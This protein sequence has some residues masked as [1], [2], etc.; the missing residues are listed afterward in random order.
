MSKFKTNI[1]VHRKLNRIFA[2]RKDKEISNGLISEKRTTKTYHYTKK[3]PVF[4]SF[5]K[6]SKY[7]VYYLDNY[8]F[9][10]F[11]SPS[12]WCYTLEQI[13]IK[14]KSKNERIH[15]NT[16]DLGFNFDYYLYTI[17]NITFK[18]FLFKL[19]I[20]LDEDNNTII[21]DY[22]NYHK[23]G[24]YTE[25]SNEF[26]LNINNDRNKLHNLDK[27]NKILND[28]YRNELIEDQRRIE[29]EMYDKIKEIKNKYTPL[30]DLASKKIYNRKEEIKEEIGYNEL[31]SKIR[32]LEFEYRLFKEYFS[33][34]GFGRRYNIDYRS[35]SNNFSNL[36]II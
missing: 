15:I 34:E 25:K 30:I 32:M 10:F 4:R 3:N 26:L 13:E 18:D 7:I 31:Y 22:Y 12:Y 6:D 11:Y 17:D 2:E 1:T 8:V 5:P 27:S 36:R 9:S 14:N 20:V 21:N 35:I 16:N 24:F 19:N 33:L 28:K 29:K 23:S